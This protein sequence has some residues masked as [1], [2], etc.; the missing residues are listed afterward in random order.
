MEYE[1]H[2]AAEC[3]RLMDDDELASLVA[4]IK[5]NG[6]VDAIVLGQ[7]NSVATKKLV[8]GRSR[9]KACGLAGVEPRFETRQF[10][11]DAEIRAFVASRSERRNLTRGQSAMRLAMLW[12]EPQPGK[13]TKGSATTLSETNKVSTARIS[14]ARMVLRY[15]PELAIAVRDG[16]RSLDDAIK[17]VDAERKALESA[18]AMSARLRSEAPD[19]ADLVVDGRIKLT[20]AV[21]ALDE[22][23]RT[24]DRERRT[25]T[26]LLNSVFNILWPRGSNPDEWAARLLTD[27]DLK[28]WL[29]T[30]GPLTADTLLSCAKTMQSIANQWRQSHD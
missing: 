1:V 30:N 27:V 23:K 4:D 22:R 20:E 11:D 16:V 26:E 17:Q 25:A 28:F 3:V 19:L 6:L 21:G 5:A 24:A 15:S 12:P 2:P 29:T 7:V 9:L 8:D 13:K 18:E 10:A 14:Q